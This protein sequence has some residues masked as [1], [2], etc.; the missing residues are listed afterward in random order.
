MKFY[1]AKPSLY[2]AAH[3]VTA[4]KRGGL[5]I[6]NVRYD[7]DARFDARHLARSWPS[8]ASAGKALDKL[9]AVGGFTDY[10]IT[11]TGPSAA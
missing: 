4:I 10:A 2:G 7:P 5:S 1:I 3:Y 6:D 9:H 11:Q 8:A